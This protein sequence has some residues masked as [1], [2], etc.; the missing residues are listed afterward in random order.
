MILIYVMIATIKIEKY[1]NKKIKAK[2]KQR[3]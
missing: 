3:I 2:A 1:K